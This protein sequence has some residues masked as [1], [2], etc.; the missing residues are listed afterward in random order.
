MSA[1]PPRMASRIGSGDPC[2]A[3]PRPKPQRAT[4]SDAN[5]S[6]QRIASFRRKPSPTTARALTMRMSR[7]GTGPRSRR[8][9]RRRRR[10]GGRRDSCVVVR[11]RRYGRRRG[12]SRVSRPA[13]IGTV[14]HV[15]ARAFT[16]P[17]RLDRR[18]R[19]CAVRAEDAAVAGLGPHQR[20][21]LG[22]LVEEQ[23]G[24][25]RH[26]Q[27]VGMPAGGTP[28]RRNE[29]DVS[30][31][32]GKGDGRAVGRTGRQSVRWLPQKRPQHAL[33]SGAAAGAAGTVAAAGVSAAVTGMGS[34]HGVRVYVLKMGQG[35]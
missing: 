6:G 3:R 2:T 15:S 33:P 1:A 27:R 18:A 28:E 12:H 7:R 10:R 35:L 9:A 14:R 11:Y 8:R 23:A 32:F 16:P 29:R 22:A 17:A 19:H 31:G 21:A 13:A 20:S 5:I 30:H 25:R 26:R 34:E 24:I 4:A